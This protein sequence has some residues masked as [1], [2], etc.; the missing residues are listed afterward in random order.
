VLRKDLFFRISVGG[1]GDPN[2]KLTKSKTLARKVLQR[3]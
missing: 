1:A 3:L 2:T